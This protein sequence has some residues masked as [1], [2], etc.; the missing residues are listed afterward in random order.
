MSD[1]RIWE[2][3]EMII[4][5][6]LLKRLDKIRDKFNQNFS[7]LEDTLSIIDDESGK[8]EGEFECWLG[9]YDDAALKKCFER[10]VKSLN[11]NKS[12]ALYFL[13]YMTMEAVKLGELEIGIKDLGKLDDS[14]IISAF[15]PCSKKDSEGTDDQIVFRMDKNFLKHVVNV[16][17]FIIDKKE[18]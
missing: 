11:G 6:K 15:Y 10:F 1:V 3:I 16:E 9:D 4:K 18:K 14:R 8:L 17:M 7:V 5:N 2:K 12:L 13:A